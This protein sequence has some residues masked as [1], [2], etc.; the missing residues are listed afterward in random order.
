VK[1]DVSEDDMAFIFRAEE[2]AKQE[3]SMEQA[4]G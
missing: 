3:T 4:A 2:Q 1:A